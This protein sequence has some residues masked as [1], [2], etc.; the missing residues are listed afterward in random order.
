MRVDADDHSGSKN[1]KK[2][3]RAEECNMIRDESRSVCICIC[4]YE[5][6]QFMKMLEG[7]T[8][9]GMHGT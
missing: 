3:K 1:L 5:C 4:M 6:T 2:K 8:V 9:E 7:N